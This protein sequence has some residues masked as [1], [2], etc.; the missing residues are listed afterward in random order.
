MMLNLKKCVR[1]SIFLLF[2]ILAGYVTQAK[3]MAAEPDA[4]TG[5]LV[6]TADRGF[7]GNQETGDGFDAFAAGRNADILYV[8]DARS[9]DILNQKL[10]GLTEKGA[11]RIIVLPLFISAANAR[12]QMAESWLEEYSHK[13]AQ[14]LSIARPY[15]SSYLAVEDL[16]DR[17]RQAPTDKKKL[18]VIGSGATDEKSREQMKADLLQMAQFASTAEDINVVIASSWGAAR[19]S[20]QQYRDALKN[21]K[22]TLVIPVALT[23]KADSMM[24]FES[25]LP[26]SVAKDAQLVTSNFSTTA[27]LAQWMEYATNEVLLQSSDANSGAIGAIA[28][29]HGSNWFWNQS[30]RDALAPVA[31]NYPL[32]FTFSMADQPTIERAVRDMEKKGVHGIVLVR[33][34]G[35]ASSFRPTVERMIGADVTSGNGAHH[36]GH[37]MDMSMDMGMD[38][39]HGHGG[40]MMH[41]DHAMSTL[42]APPRI[43]TSLPIITVGGVE[44]SPYFAKA[45]LANARSVSIDPSRETIILTAHGAGADADNEHWLGLLGNLAKQMKNEDGYN[46][47][48]IRAVTWREDWPDKNKVEVANARKLVKEI[49]D[50]GGHVLIVPAR[51]NGRGAADV[52]LQGL[53]FGWSQGFAQTPYFSSWFEDQV[54]LGVGQLTRGTQASKDAHDHHHAS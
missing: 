7:L 31:K 29:A 53:N 2:A 22:D 15:G 5:I 26:R 36:G 14:S 18:L 28:L 45:L 25:G 48:D 19:E 52:Y 23:S 34:F 13:G 37:M 10:A 9:K 16:A 30:I 17:L 20:Q 41:G 6:V 12:W 4:K 11:N 54:T 35:E 1:W 40:M 33:I 46:F 44:D 27:G 32:V 21:T 42:A 24:S 50:A 43:R 47:K 3:S 8:T 51:T 38:M 39:S 49:N